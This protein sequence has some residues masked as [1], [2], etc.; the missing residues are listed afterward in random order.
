[1][2]GE[3][4]TAAL[5][6]AWDA[7]RDMG[8][9]VAVMG[10]IAL[11]AWLHPRNTRDVDLLIGVA[12]TDP[13]SLVRGMQAHGF[14]PL[15][16]PALVDVGDARF[17]QFMYTPPGTYVD[18]KV[19][20]QLAESEFQKS[21]LDRRKQ[22]DWP[23]RNLHIEAVSCEDLIL[24]KLLAERMID[25]ADVIALIQANAYRL[26]YDYLRPWLDRL[27]VK[28]RWSEFWGEAFPGEADPVA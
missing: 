25:R 20:L 18:I 14:R 27:K 24:L 9:P 15:R 13:D 2:F 22:F 8:H 21:A 19:D 5:R 1:M 16:F 11:T 7:V 6:A 26:D 17:I 4:V 23:E 10:G 12:N 3:M 28:Q